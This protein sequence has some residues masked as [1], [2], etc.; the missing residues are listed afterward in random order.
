MVQ[1]D[2]ML[3]EGLAAGLRSDPQAAATALKSIVE[4]ARRRAAG[5][6]F[7]LIRS[8]ADGADDAVERV[9]AETGLLDGRLAALA[10][11]AQQAF[12][13][14]A[15]MGG[16]DGRRDNGYYRA[17]LAHAQRL[18]AMTD[19]ALR[20]VELV[21]LIGDEGRETKDKE[22]GPETKEEEM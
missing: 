7:S 15:I 12:A 14:L 1:D 3:A 22:E 8:L 19:G 21:N 5:G 2:L 18:D 6:D 17:P 4:E 11:L 10:T 13:V 16:S 20:L 9:R